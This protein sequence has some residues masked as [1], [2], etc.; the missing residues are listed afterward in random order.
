[1]V[2]GLGKHGDMDRSE[3]NRVD[4]ISL[5]GWSEVA[6]VVGKFR[7]LLIDFDGVARF[8]AMPAE[9]APARYAGEDPPATPDPEA[10]FSSP[11]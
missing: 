7:N 5:R 3:F 2:R 6:A 8:A 11:S 1:M 4:Q 9:P 10:R